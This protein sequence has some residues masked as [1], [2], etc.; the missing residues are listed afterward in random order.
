MNLFSLT[1]P[2]LMIYQCIITVSFFAWLFLGTI[3]EWLI[4]LSVYFVRGL[5]SSS[6]IH[7]GITHRAFKIPKLLEYV[8]S[9]IAIAGGNASVITWVAVHREHHRYSDTDKDPHSPKYQSYLEIHLR[10]IDRP[11]DIRFAI[12]LV[13]SKYYIFAHKWHWLYSLIII[14]CLYFIDPRAIFYAWFVPNFI[15]WH[16]GSLVN[17]LNHSGFG[18]RSY[19]TDDQSINNPITGYLSF[20]EG[21]HNNHHKFPKDPQFGKKWWEIDLGWY[22]IKAIRS[23]K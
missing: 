6:I 14:T 18:Y 5:L 23:D 3:N 20:G 9:T 12:D 13:K 19:E 2:S 10:T 21:W 8:L 16:S 4:A 22:L 15:Q 17:S 11:P 7:R 1:T